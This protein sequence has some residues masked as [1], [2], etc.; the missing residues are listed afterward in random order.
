MK[1]SSVLGLLIEHVLIDDCDFWVQSEVH[2]WNTSGGRQCIG[3]HSEN[4]TDFHRHC[5][6]HS[7]DSLAVVAAALNPPSY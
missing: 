1:T 2:K 6:R 7:I 5:R 4:D 3:Q